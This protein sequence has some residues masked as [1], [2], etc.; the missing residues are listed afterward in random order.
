MKHL[1]PNG[2]IVMPMRLIGDFGTILGNMQFQMEKMRPIQ[3][4]LV[5]LSY[6]II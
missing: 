6:A 4:K 1:K 3:S 5:M 2:I